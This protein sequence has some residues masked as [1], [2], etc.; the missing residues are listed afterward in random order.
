MAQNPPRTK[1]AQAA[2]ATASKVIVDEVVDLKV[3]THTYWGRIQDGKQEAGLA[4]QFFLGHDRPEVAGMDAIP[5]V[6]ITVEF[7]TD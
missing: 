1:Q 7:V 2:T 4:V 3:G 6:R 5:P